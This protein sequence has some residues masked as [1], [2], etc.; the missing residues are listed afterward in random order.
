MF[1]SFAESNVFP[2]SRRSG[3]RASG[4]V[5]FNAYLSTRKLGGLRSVNAK[6]V[7]VVD[8]GA[9]SQKKAERSID[10]RKARQSQSPKREV[11]LRSDAR[12]RGS[13][14][15][16]RDRRR[17]ARGPRTGK[18]F[19]SITRVASEIGMLPCAEFSS[20]FIDQSFRFLSLRL[21]LLK[22]AEHM[23]SPL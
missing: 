10:E 6:H 22:L 14:A 23:P 20:M 18:F 19:P 5:A 12:K 3:T 13:A 9:Y 21:L 1:S 11:H 8:L 16:R 4:C 7:S 17:R 2:T 15:A